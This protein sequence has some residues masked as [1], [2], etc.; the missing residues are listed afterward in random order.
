VL[1]YSVALHS[2]II[3]YSS[4]ERYVVL[5]S[6]RLS[7]QGPQGLLMNG[8]YT[9]QNATVFRT[10][11]T[12]GRRN[13]LNSHSFYFCHA[14]VWFH[15][16]FQVTSIPQ[17]FFG[18]T[19][20]CLQEPDIKS[21]NTALCHHRPLIN[22]PLDDKTPKKWGWSTL[23]ISLQHARYEDH[24]VEVSVYERRSFPRLL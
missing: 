1:K 7:L 24:F 4:M 8:A 2:G 11:A 5:Q 10:T 3:L 22:H 12:T 13:A 20:S 18:R 21:R 23:I 19:R 15:F 16:G 6:K 9:T 14:E 17:F